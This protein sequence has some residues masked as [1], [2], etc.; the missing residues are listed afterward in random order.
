[1]GDRTQQYAA[2][3]AACRALLRRAATTQA[4]LPDPSRAE[5][6][7]AGLID[8]GISFWVR[9]PI[10]VGDVDGD[11]DTGTD[12]AIP[13]DD[14]EDITSLASHQTASLQPSNL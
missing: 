12:T 10:D 8:R 4:V 5:G 7:L 11:A 2:D 6:L 14:D 9:A 3:I 1:M 13:D